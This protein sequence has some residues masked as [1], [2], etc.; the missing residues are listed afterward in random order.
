[1]NEIK[2]ELN[3]IKDLANNALQGLKDS[4]NGLTKGLNFDLIKNNKLVSIAVVLA[5]LYF[6]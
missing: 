6:I 4:A 3:K 5:V 2:Q 1:M